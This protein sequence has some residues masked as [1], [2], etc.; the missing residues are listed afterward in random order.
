MVKSCGVR[1][2]IEAMLQ[3]HDIRESRVYQEAMKE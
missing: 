2:E 3:I 1:E